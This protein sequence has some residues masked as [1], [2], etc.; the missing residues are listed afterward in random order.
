MSQAIT[1]AMVEAARDAFKAKCGITIYLPGEGTLDDFEMERYDALKDA[2]SAAL[3][4]PLPEIEGGY[5]GDGWQPI[6]TAPKEATGCFEYAC[7]IGFV[8]WGK[9]GRIH[10]HVGPAIWQEFTGQ[11]EFTETS[12]DIFPAPTHWHPFPAPSPAPIEGETKP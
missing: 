12:F 1:E 6:D 4:V 8:T 2:L 11:W 9:E 7:I 5:K 10:T 3:S